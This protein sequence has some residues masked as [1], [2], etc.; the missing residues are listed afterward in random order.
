MAEQTWTL[1]SDSNGSPVLAHTGGDIHYSLRI[2]T[3]TGTLK[4]QVS[5]D[6][7]GTWNDITDSSHTAAVQKNIVG[8]PSGVL[9]RPNLSGSASTPS[10]VVKAFSVTR[11]GA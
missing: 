5:Y 2:A 6:E 10:F 4:M 1:T 11:F 9:I 8:M 3:G 7:G